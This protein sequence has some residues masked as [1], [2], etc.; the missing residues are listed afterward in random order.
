MLPKK[1]I[2]KLIK[3]FLYQQLDEEEAGLTACLV[4]HTV[5]KPAEKVLQLSIINQINRAVKKNFIRFN[6]EL[7]R[8]SATWTI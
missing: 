3:E 6:K 7:K 2:E 4:I 1:E 8:F 5:N